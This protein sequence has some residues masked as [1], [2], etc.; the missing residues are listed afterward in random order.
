MKYLLSALLFCTLLS[1]E[2]DNDEPPLADGQY[3]SHGQYYRYQ[4]EMY[5]SNGKITDTAIIYNYLRYH[6]SRSMTGTNYAELLA[7]APQVVMLTD[8]I[9]L[10]VNGQAGTLYMRD[11]FRAGS[12]GNPM[13]YQ[14]H[15]IAVIAGT[16]SEILLQHQ[17][18]TGVLKGWTPNPCE[19][20]ISKLDKYVP[21][22]NCRPTATGEYCAYRDVVPVQQAVSSEIRVLYY[23][24]FNSSP[25][26]TGLSSHV[27]NVPS[28]TIP[29]ALSAQDTVVIQ[30]KE[31][32]LKKK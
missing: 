29:Q 10:T 26:C 8:S 23:S 12:P 31:I 19:T 9:K 3:Q 15:S 17:D 1:C 24:R 16:Q 28:L 27:F 18:S 2:K 13:N 22:K 6:S 11:Y 5:T 14:T 20:I 25:S 4:P 7:T 32:I 30:R 21:A